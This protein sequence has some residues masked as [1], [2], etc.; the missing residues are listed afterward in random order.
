MLPTFEQYESGRIGHALHFAAAGYSPD[1][2]WPARASDGVIPGHPLRAGARLRL[3]AQ[4]RDRLLGA[5]GRTPHDR[6]LV[7]CMATEGLIV[8]DFTDPDA[9]DLLRQPQDPRIVLS[10]TSIRR[11]DLE[12]LA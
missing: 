6:A 3:T 5:P 12:V 1:H 10:I 2:I 11:T 7:E 4:A 9:G 8:D